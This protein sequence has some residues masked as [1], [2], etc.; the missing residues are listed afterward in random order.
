ML[1]RLDELSLGKDRKDIGLV[2]RQAML[3]NGI[4]HNCEAWS[5]FSNQDIK[6][7][8]HPK[9]IQNLAVMRQILYHHKK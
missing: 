8:L 6:E 1:A 2:L 5:T 3:L 9:T 4:L 7:M